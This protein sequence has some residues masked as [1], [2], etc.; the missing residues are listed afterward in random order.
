MPS[1]S[2]SAGAAGRLPPT[3]GGMKA[4]FAPRLFGG[5]LFLAPALLVAGIWYLHFLVPMPAKQAAWESVVG[6]LRHDFESPHAWWF[7][8]LVALPALCILLSA[9]YFLNVARG[10]TGALVLFAA[11]LALAVA[12]FVLNDWGLAVFV[13][14][15]AVW[16]YRA[17]HAT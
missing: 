4:R 7:T 17:I 8:W 5:W 14:L 12:T 13:A 9:A 1:S 10:R 16:G 11:T 6:Q 2:A 3:L 15:P